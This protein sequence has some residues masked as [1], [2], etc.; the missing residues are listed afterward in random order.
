MMLYICV[1]FH[2]N[3][4]NGFQLTERTRVNSRNGEFSIIYYIQRVVN[5]SYL[6]YSKGRYYKSRLT[7]VMYFF[8]FFFFFFFFVVVFFFFFFF[9]L[10]FFFF[11]FFFV[12]CTLSH[13]ALHL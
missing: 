12:L 7:R 5:F 3:I 13:D 2:Q 1:K 8:F 11:F 4:W 9:L 6:L 10:L